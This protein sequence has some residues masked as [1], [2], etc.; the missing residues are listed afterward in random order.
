MDRFVL[1]LDNA[2]KAMEDYEEDMA[3]LNEAQENMLEYQNKISAAMLE[4]IQYKVEVQFDLNDR[5]VKQLQYLRN[6]WED[7]L[8]KQD[9]SFTKMTEEALIYED[10]LK[11]LGASFDEL[12]AAYADGTLNQADYASGMQDLNDKMLEQ[13]ENLLTIKKSIKEAYGNTLE[14]ANQELEKYNSILEH[15]RNVM[16]SYI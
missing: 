10:N 13:L 4:G 12:N 5:D 1:R 6:S 9:D 14:M 2:K 7:F 11:I 15:S 8:D 3:K 16:Q